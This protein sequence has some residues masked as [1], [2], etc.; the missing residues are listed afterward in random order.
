[1]FILFKIN[2]ISTEY[3]P[4]VTLCNQDPEERAGFKNLIILSLLR[5]LTDEEGSIM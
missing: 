4:Y 5:T 1:M 3:K 2:I